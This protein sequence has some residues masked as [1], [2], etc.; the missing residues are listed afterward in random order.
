M[1]TLMEVLERVSGRAG[2]M[3]EI[4]ASG[5]TESVEAIVREAGFRGSLFYASFLHAEILSIRA[6]DSSATTIALLE[7]VPVEQTAFARDAQA[8]H[9]G[10]AIGSLSN[11]FVRKLH[12]AGFRVFTYTV[13]EP[14]EIAYAKGCNVDGIISNYPDRL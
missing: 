12:D 8:T 7:G 5:I 13:D 2:L 10:L 1:P 6:R 4:K 11:S 9:A 14:E 3:I